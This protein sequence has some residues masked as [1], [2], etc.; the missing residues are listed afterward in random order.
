MPITS[1]PYA[2]NGDP[3]PLKILM[4]LGPG[5][6]HAG[7][8]KNNE[9]SLQRILTQIETRIVHFLYNLPG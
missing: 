2:L 1:S 7:M 6:K 4:A 3:V 8:T 5:Q 9:Q